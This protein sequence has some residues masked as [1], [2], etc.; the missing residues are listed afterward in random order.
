[1]IY[2]YTYAYLYMYVCVCLYVSLSVVFDC[3]LP[4]GCSPPGSTVH[5]I[6]QAIILEWVGYHSLLQGIFPTQGSTLICRQIL[7]HL[8][9][10]T[11]NMYVYYIHNRM[12]QVCFLQIKAF[13]WKSAERWV[14]VAVFSGGESYLITAFQEGDRTTLGSDTS[15]GVT[16]TQ[17]GES[18]NSLILIKASL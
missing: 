16:S 17:C 15:P 7:Y 1:M 4:H 14:F 6:L 13:I 8:S 2:L 11:P 5:G 10:Q 9:R 12:Q 18:T 3:L